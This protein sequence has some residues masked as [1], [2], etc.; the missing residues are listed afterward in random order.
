MIKEKIKRSFL[1]LQVFLSHSGVCSRRKA[2]ELIQQGFVQVNG[3]E[4]R[5]PSTPIDPKK[6]KVEVKGRP[7]VSKAYEYVMLN[8]PKGYVTT[9]ADFPGEKSVLD[10]LPKELQ[11]LNPVGRLDKDTE[12]LL[13]LTNDGD[14]AYRL[15][16]PKFRIDKVYLVK[17]IDV[18]TAE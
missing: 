10:L 11:H 14:V 15:T 3:Q 4:I 9:T 12:G 18:L 17:I 8:K 16:H 7:V 2:M 5:E 6:D 1:R 13:L